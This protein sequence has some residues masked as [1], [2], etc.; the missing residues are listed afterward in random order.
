MNPEQIAE[1]LSKSVTSALE[2]IGKGQQTPQQNGDVQQVVGAVSSLSKI[3]EAVSQKVDALDKTTVK[4]IPEPVEE[5]VGKLAKTIEA[6]TTKVDALV[7]GE[8]PAE[9]DIDLS[10]I[11]TKKDL[12]KLIKSMTD[13]KDE[14][15]DDKGTPKGKGK[16]DLAKL[17][18]T[19]VK[20]KGGEEIEIEAD[21]VDIEDT[22]AAGNTLSK[23]QKTDRA[24]LDKHLG[25]MMGNMMERH[26]VETDD[27]E[28]DDDDDE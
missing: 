28:D 24:A 16:D 17:L 13:E 2:N 22:D 7:K 19:L 11:K 8:K 5:T 9:D 12:M 20:G 25:K 3:V 10:K 14:E 23:K 1:M 15:E 6:L 27:A 18:K 4:N 21:E 26:G